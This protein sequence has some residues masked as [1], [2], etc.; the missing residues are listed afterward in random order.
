[1][2]E[3]RQRLDD[4]RFFEREILMSIFGIM[5]SPQD[6]ALVNAVNHVA[7]AVLKLVP[8]GNQGVDCATKADLEDLKSELL[9]A[10]E[11]IQTTSE[12][13]KA[14]LDALLLRI[15]AQSMKLEALDRKI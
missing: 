10:I 14:I 2:D 11:A 3:A 13:D 5:S 8:G 9:S 6:K 7:D 4:S 1:M 15:Q 12:E